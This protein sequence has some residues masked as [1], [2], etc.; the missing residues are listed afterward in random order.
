MDIINPIN[1]SCDK[2]WSKHKSMLHI[3]T[4]GYTLKIN[5]SPSRINTESKYPHP[6]TFGGGLS[7]N[8]NYFKKTRRSKSEPN[9]GII[10]A[11]PRHRRQTKV[12]FS[13]KIH[14]VKYVCACQIMKQD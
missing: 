5:K 7:R 12:H 4:N 14:N 13:R 1:K 2:A 3:W 8:M 11:V 10:I 6:Y 9:L